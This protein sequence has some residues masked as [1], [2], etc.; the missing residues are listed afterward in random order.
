MGT[1]FKSCWTKMNRSPL[2]YANPTTVKPLLSSHASTLG[3]RGF[4]CAVSGFSQVLKRDLREKPCGFVARV[5]GLWPN[6]C[7]PVADET[8]F[9]FA[10]EKKPLVPRVAVWSINFPKFSSHIYWKLTSI[11]WSPL[12]SRHGHHLDFPNG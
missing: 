1:H 8:K 2:H 7:R 6:M 3:A 10:C 12:L 9:P 4:S 11:Q 5:I